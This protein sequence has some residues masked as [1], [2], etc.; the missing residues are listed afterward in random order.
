MEGESGQ[1]HINEAVK[2]WMERLRELCKGYS[3]EDIWNEDETGCFFW[4]L[5]EKSLAEDKGRCKGGKKSKLRMTVA[6]LTN[7]SGDKEEPIVIWKSNN[8]T[9][10]KNLPDKQPANVKYFS[11]L[12]LWMN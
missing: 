1:V 6:F 9:C 8:P 11:N 4:A 12:K 5:P 2:S 7:A 3:P 10:F